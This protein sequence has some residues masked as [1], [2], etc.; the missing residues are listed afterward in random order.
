M[1]AKLS[2]LIL[3]C[4]SAIPSST[5]EVEIPQGKLRGDTRT[6][7]DGGVFYSFKNI[8]YAKPPVGKLRFKAPEKAESWYGVRDATEELPQCLQILSSTS[9]GQEDCLYLNVY[10]SE[11]PNDDVRSKAV[12]VYIYGGAFMAGDAREE[13]YGPQFLLTKDVVVVILNYRIGIFGFL[14]LDDP[15]LGVTGNAGL[16]D[17]VLALKWVK[18]NIE[19]FGGDPTNIL[20][21]GHSAGA[22][23]VHLQLL[24]PMSEGLFHKALSQ[25]G[26]SLSPLISKD[27][28]NNAAIIAKYLNIQTA[29]WPEMLNTL[30]EV[31][32]EN[33]VNAERALNNI[34]YPHLSLP[35][36][37][38]TSSNIS[39][40]LESE[41]VKIIRSGNFK[42]IPYLHG[43]TD[44]DG[45]V[46]FSEVNDD[47][48]SPLI[49]N[50]TQYIPLDLKITPQSEAEQNIVQ[51]FKNFYYKGE[52]SSRENIT[53]D[54]QFFTDY[55]FAYPHYRVTVEQLKKTSNPIYL[56]YFSAI[57]ELNGVN[58]LNYQGVGHGADVNYLWYTG[59]TSQLGSIEDLVSRNMVNMWTN[60]AIYGNPTPKGFNYTWEPVQENHI[61]YLHISNEGFFLEENILQDNLQLWSDLYKKYYKSE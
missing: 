11:L 14:S 15:N 39:T 26:V 7:R 37:E 23:S 58:P 50:I 34:G 40:F 31:S 47:G 10:T 21:F 52:E 17:Q 5:Q 29:R 36:V 43:F 22:M 38:I 3:I 6:N 27:L 42:K 1:W 16:K 56:Y 8:P 48:V 51:K 41:P 13:T 59:K 54:I 46:I 24:S 61:K 19:Y 2:F 20:L 25:S 18:E 45:L 60:F 4:D 9:Q 12:M 33:L 53:G 55:A 28:R 57:T 30:Q 44:A 35:I 32:A 49:S